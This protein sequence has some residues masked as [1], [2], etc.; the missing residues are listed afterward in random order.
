MYCSQFLLRV[1]CDM[2]AECHPRVQPVTGECLS[3]AAT[4]TPGQDPVP[5]VNSR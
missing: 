5:T 2:P 4:P 1:L 3:P